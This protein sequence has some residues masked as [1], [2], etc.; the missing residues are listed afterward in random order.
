MQVYMWL[1]H[2]ITSRI[3]I[4]QE[5]NFKFSFGKMCVG[6]SDLVGVSV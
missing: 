3:M 6:K 1:D 5:N 2:L 4:I